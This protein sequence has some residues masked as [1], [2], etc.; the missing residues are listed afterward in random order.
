MELGKI[1]YTFLDWFHL[2]VRDDG[3][4]DNEDGVCR[5][6]PRAR[7]GS[8][9]IGAFAYLRYFGEGGTVVLI[10]L[11]ACFI[12]LADGVARKVRLHSSSTLGNLGSPFRG[13][14]WICSSVS[15]SLPS[16]LAFGFCLL[17]F[18][19]EFIPLFPAFAMFL[20]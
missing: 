17:N 15:D 3:K 7:V 11:S 16:L 19:L 10:S 14:S 18:L 9:V 8:Q 1:D 2:R 4:D 12:L 6:W 5:R 20:M 13:C